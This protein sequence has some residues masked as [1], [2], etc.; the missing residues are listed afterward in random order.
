MQ[1]FLAVIHVLESGFGLVGGSSRQ[2]ESVALQVHT[3]KTIHVISITF[4]NT[5]ALHEIIMPH[6]S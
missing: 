2:K 6:Y 1:T 3:I 5:T 4:W